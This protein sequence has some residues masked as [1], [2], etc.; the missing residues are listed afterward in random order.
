MNGRKA[1]TVKAKSFSWKF[2]ECLQC[3]LQF[4]SSHHKGTTV[5]FDGDNLPPVALEA[6]QKPPIEGIA[7]TGQS[8]SN[9][10]THYSRLANFDGLAKF[11]ISQ[12]SF[13]IRDM[14][15]G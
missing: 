5:Q 2:M 3:H 14:K 7:T 13:I 1:N 4:V 9:K 10:L 15:A 11:F 6:G 12:P 8:F